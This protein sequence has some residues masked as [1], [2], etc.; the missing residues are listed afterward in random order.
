[1]TAG[2]PRILHTAYDPQPPAMLE[3]PTYIAKCVA[4]P[5]NDAWAGTHKCHEGLNQGSTDIE[6]DR[7]RIEI[8]TERRSVLL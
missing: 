5:R 7:H 4:I 1:M 3:P 2:H 6:R 8:M